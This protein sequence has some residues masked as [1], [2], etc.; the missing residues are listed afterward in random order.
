M[1]ELRNTALGPMGST[2]CSGGGRWREE[3]KDLVLL[4]RIIAP[5]RL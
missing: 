3:V 2:R 5:N 1:R 4:S